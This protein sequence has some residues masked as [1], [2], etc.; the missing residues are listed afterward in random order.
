MDKASRSV[1][2]TP[3]LGGGGEGVVDPAP[4]NHP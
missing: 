4:H 1:T 2:G 3:L